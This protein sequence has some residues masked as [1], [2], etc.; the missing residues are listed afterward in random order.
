M[1][2][3]PRPNW[4]PI[5]DEIARVLADDPGLAA[6]LAEFDRAYETG[7]AELVPDEEVRRRLKARDLHLSPDPTAPFAS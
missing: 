1:G 6:G 3:W 2:A 4:Q 5:D 7:E